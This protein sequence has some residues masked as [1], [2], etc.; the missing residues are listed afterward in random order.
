MRLDGLVLVLSP[1]SSEHQHQLTGWDHFLY[2]NCS[3]F[4]PLFFQRSSSFQSL[5][6][7][8]IISR[9]S[10]DT[11][12]SSS[13]MTECNCIYLEEF[14][15]DSYA[16]IFLFVYIDCFYLFSA[17][18]CTFDSAHGRSYIRSECFLMSNLMFSFLCTAVSLQCNSEAI[19]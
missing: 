10:T 2:F 5:L 4:T 1:S 15:I 9:R 17:H 16:T 8:C 11:R 19:K 7:H 18:A 12:L 6:A 13:S 14:V 3:L